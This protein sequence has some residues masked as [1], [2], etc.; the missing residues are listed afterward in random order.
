MLDKQTVNFNKALTTNAQKYE[1]QITVG[2]AKINETQPRGPEIRGQGRIFVPT[3]VEDLRS[4]MCIESDSL[5]NRT[6]TGVLHPASDEAQASDL[7]SYFNSWRKWRV[8]CGH[9]QRW[10]SKLSFMQAR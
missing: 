7:F 8:H 10:A 5:L 2:Y 9:A 1:S 4:N 3:D 6:S